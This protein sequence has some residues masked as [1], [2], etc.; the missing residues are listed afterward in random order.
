MGKL[1]P[2]RARQLEPRPKLEV[3]DREQGGGGATGERAAAGRETCR[4]ELC[5]GDMKAEQ[6]FKDGRSNNMTAHHEPFN[7][8]H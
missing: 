5:A 3:I 8:V 7:S 4:M 1:R 2:W 6:H